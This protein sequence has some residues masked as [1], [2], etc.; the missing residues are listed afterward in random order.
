MSFRTRVVSSLAWKLFERA[1]TQGLQ[2]FVQLVL[3]RLLVPEDYGV[4]ALLAIFISSANVFVQ[5]GLSTALIQRLDVDETDFSSVLY[6]S[7]S[8][9]CIVYALLFLCAPAISQFYR[10]PQ[11]SAFLRVLSL[12]LFSGAFS[13]VQHAVLARRMEFR[14]SFFSSLGA[15]L[16]SG[17][18]G[19][20]MAYSGYG[21]WAL[22][23]QQLT[24]QALVAGILLATVRWRPS[25]RF[26][27]ERVRSLFS[28]GWKILASSLLD[29][30]YNEMRSL[31]IGKLYTADALGYYNRGR[32][33]PYMII[34]N[35]NGP[36]QT[37]ML[38]TLSSCQNDRRR[39]KA[40]VRRSIVTSSFVVFPTMIGLAVVARPLVQVLLTDKWLPSVP[41]L[42]I[43]CLAYALWPI[44][45]AN[46]Q[47]INALGRSDIFLKLELFKKLLGIV[48][49]G[50][51][52]AYGIYAIAVGGIVSSLVFTL[53]NSHPNR[54]LLNYSVK[55]QI[56]DVFPPLALSLAMGLVIHMMNYYM[57]MAAH[58]TLIV[59]VATGLCIYVGLAKVLKLES[60]AY[61]LMICRGMLIGKRR[62]IGVE[63]VR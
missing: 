63:I 49:L 59:Q 42:Q 11:L 17:P 24:H 45:T 40:M 39:V 25:M 27:L 52:V 61:I 48:I 43:N 21:A 4:I 26:S 41:F 20:M 2:F 46:L 9:A 32:Q 36:I 19:I 56:R 10:M 55:E 51:T 53:I 37:V 3:A 47:A 6:M 44:H 29:T 58:A 13:S 15:V 8:L 12:T 33:F 54:R 62:S 34:Q 60:L 7:L 35:I 30:L 1:G 5:S 18:I 50:V 16:I 38:P 23:F 22:V 31:V 28:Y 57:Q 14:K